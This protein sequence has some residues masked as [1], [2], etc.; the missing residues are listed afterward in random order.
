MELG[1]TPHT[2]NQER[3]FHILVEIRIAAEIG[4]QPIC[5]LG[6]NVLQ[7]NEPKREMHNNSAIHQP[8]QCLLTQLLFVNPE[9]FSW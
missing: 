8:K 5:F 1:D 9:T 2:W 6:E 7:N 3:G 4:D